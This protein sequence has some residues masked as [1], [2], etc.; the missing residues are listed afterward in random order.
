MR[1]ERDS[2]VIEMR[3][4]RIR[5]RGHRRKNLDPPRSRTHVVI[6]STSSPSFQAAVAEVPFVAGRIVEERGATGAG[7]QRERAIILPPSAPSSSVGR[8]GW[9]SGA[10]R[11]MRESRTTET[12]VGRATK[13]GS[14]WERVWETSPTDS[15]HC[16][17]NSL[18]TCSQ[19]AIRPGTC[20]APARAHEV[21]RLRDHVLVR[22]DRM[23]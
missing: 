8:P 9:S 12:L 15:S 6:A 16:R 10:C 19:Y 7:P 1:I 4:D 22:C 17:A 2:H 23:Q 11:L 20:V 3:T 5:K 18:L 21:R 14:P 13:L